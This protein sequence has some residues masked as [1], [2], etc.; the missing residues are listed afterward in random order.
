[1]A[2]S[3][4][5]KPRA[6]QWPLDQRGVEA[7]DRNFDDIFRRV[8]AVQTGENPILDATSFSDVIS[9]TVTRGDI[10]T[11]QVDSSDGTIK[12]DDLAIGAAGKLLR[13]DGTDLLYST[14]TI[15]DTFATGSLPH[16]SSTNTLTALAA[17][18]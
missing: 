12:W 11:G 14:F 7:I 10:I 4:S 15:P 1:M 18:G 16:A 6:I 5:T 9:S 17:G 8:V 13:S 3:I 2:G